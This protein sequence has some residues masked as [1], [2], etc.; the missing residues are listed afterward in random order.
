MKIWNE[1]LKTGKRCGLIGPGFG[2][3]PSMAYK[4]VQSFYKFRTLCIIKSKG[5]NWERSQ[6]EGIPFKV[7]LSVIELKI[8]PDEKF[9]DSNYYLNI[10]KT[11]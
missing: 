9:L 3:S 4:T 2:V 5:N 10:R 11:I 6:L 8:K 1:Y 7:N